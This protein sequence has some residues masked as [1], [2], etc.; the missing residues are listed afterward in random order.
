MWLHFL[1]A[2][3]YWKVGIGVML[4]LALA[5]QTVRLDRAQSTIKVRNA[6]IDL[7][8][9]AIARLIEEGRQRTE[10]G[11]QAV[12]AAKPVVERIREQRERIKATTALPECRTPESVLGADL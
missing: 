2:L 1:A 6:Q 10:R 8:D 3:R 5:V 9:A 12:E 7:R 11:K 4:L